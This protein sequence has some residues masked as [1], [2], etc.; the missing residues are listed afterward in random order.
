[1][2]KFTKTHI[3]YVIVLIFFILIQVFINQYEIK[4]E[5]N[6]NIMEENQE[7]VDK[8]DCS[9]VTEKSESEEENDIECKSIIEEQKEIKQ[10]ENWQIEIPKISLI[11]NIQ[12][13]TSK[14]ILS[15]YVGHFTTTQREIGNV[16][17]A[18]HN[19]GYEVNY[20]KNLKL[21]KEG[22]EIKYKYNGI[23]KI[24]EVEKCRIIT[25]TEWKYLTNTEDNRLTLITCV[26]NQPEYRR[27]VQAVE[28]EEESY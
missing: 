25:D 16:G 17:L 9:I 10:T 23:E 20:F 22:D 1:M 4:T 7:I 27:C 11:A 24:Y 5:I 28:K 18:A 19:R 15:K 13:G 8:S 3:L 26:E 21:L 12:E 14:E 2:F 6:E